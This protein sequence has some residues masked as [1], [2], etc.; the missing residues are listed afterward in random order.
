M[1]PSAQLVI[2]SSEQLPNELRAYRF[3]GTS[4]DGTVLLSRQGA[5]YSAAH[6]EV[7]DYGEMLEGMLGLVLKNLPLD[8]RP[9]ARVALTKRWNRD[10]GVEAEDLIEAAAAGDLRGVGASANGSA[11]ATESANGRNHA[12]MVSGCTA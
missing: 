4:S 2:G 12:R 10:W 3:L 5:T 1:T 6:R 11:F 9:R 8:S 7:S